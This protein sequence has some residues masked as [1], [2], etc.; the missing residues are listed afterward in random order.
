MA[1]FLPNSRKNRQIFRRRMDCR[2]F[3]WE[4]ETRLCAL[5]LCSFRQEIQIFFGYL[6]MGFPFFFQRWGLFAPFFLKIR[7]FG[8]RALLRAAPC[9]I[10]PSAFTLYSNPWRPNSQS[11]VHQ[12]LIFFFRKKRWVFFFKFLLE[13]WFLL[14]KKVKF[15]INSIRLVLK[16]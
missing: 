11:S 14:K 3:K 9:R 8:R 7:V 2:I 10:T 13:Y 12:N 1:I 4:L 15:I 5:S 16:K 6:I